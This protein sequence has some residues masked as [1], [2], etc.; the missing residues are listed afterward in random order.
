MAVTAVGLK[1]S[2]RIDGRYDSDGS[3]S[4]WI[5]RQCAVIAVMAVMTVMTVMAVRW[6]VSVQ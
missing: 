6:K 1:R 3:D 5:K 4:S 2:A